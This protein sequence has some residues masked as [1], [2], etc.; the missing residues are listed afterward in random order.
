MDFLLAITIVPLVAVPM[1]LAFSLRDWLKARKSLDIPRP[2]ALGLVV[3]IAL[4]FAWLVPY[5]ISLTISILGLGI[6][7]S[8]GVLKVVLLT[9]PISVACITAASLFTLKGPARVQTLIA[10]LVLLGVSL[11]TVMIVLGDFEMI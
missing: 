10:G 5:S 6:D 3:I 2:S 4:F 11:L 1:L 9:W 8:A 7:F